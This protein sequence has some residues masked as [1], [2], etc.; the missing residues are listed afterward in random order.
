M[1]IKLGFF[2]ICVAF[3]GGMGLGMIGHS[4]KASDA[5]PKMAGTLVDV[6]IEVAALEAVVTYQT[7]DGEQKQW[8]AR[9][10]DANL[11]WNWLKS[12]AKPTEFD[13]VEAILG[14]MP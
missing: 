6:R 4:P 13:E 8:T 10:K 2:I 3:L 1:N 14:S 9:G 11:I 7:L 12:G 5:L